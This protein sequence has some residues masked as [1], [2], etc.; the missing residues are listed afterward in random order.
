MSQITVFDKKAQAEKQIRPLMWTLKALCTSMGLPM[1]ASVAVKNDE[2]GTEYM[3][4]TVI[5]FAPVK[6]KERLRI[7]SIL[8]YLNG[9]E[10]KLPEDVENA[11]KVL[12]KYIKDVEKLE[13][14]T[15]AEQAGDGQESVSLTDDRF[16]PY[17]EI[18][19]GGDQIDL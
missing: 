3:S 7:N 17:A 14:G 11:V 16:G 19:G 2:T 6:S 1:F 10:K 13:G 15:P 18:M 8:L 4:E 12:E 9:F 5:G